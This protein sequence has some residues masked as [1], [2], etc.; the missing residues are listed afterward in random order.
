MWIGKLRYGVL[1]VVLVRFTCLGRFSHFY[2]R[3]V[4]AITDIAIERNILEHHGIADYQ[5]WVSTLAVLTLEE[6]K[7]PARR[8]EYMHFI[9]DV[10]PILFFSGGISFPPCPR[11]S[12]L[13]GKGMRSL[14]TG[15]PVATMYGPFHKLAIIGLYL[16]QFDWNIVSIY[17]LTNVNPTKWYLN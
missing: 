11:H 12:S 14:V 7:Q 4:V 5:R 6:S 17:S 10:S 13:V 16:R 8:H 2:Q 15:D 9:A 3:T 1:A